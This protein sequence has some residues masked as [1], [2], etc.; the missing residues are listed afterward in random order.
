MFHATNNSQQ[1]SSDSRYNI[2]VETN[3]RDSSN[4]GW[5]HKFL[6]RFSG[7]NSNRSLSL[8]TAPIPGTSSNTLNSNEAR[9]GVSSYGLIG[10]TSSNRNNNKQSRKASTTGTTTTTNNQSSQLLVTMHNKSKLDSRKA[11][12]KMLMTIVV[13]F[14]ICYLPVHLINFLR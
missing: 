14:G 5:F 4:I 6:L 7:P 1:S 2:K 12:A 3:S 13:M 9:G 11:A 8:A 10:P